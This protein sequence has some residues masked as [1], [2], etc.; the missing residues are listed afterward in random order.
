[1]KIDSDQVVMMY[2]NGISFE[3]IALEFKTDIETVEYIY[4]R[5]YLRWASQYGYDN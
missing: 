5:A 3:R 2:N 1:M 4:D